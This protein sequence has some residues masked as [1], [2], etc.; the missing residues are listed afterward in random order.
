[1]FK[2]ALRI[3]LAGMALMFLM[4]CQGKKE[5]APGE[6][7][8]KYPTHQVGA[9]SSAAANAEMV[10]T[11]NEK[12]KGKYRIEVEEIPGDQ[13]YADK[14]KV[15][16][17]SGQLPDLVY[18]PDILLDV[19]YAQGVCMD[20]TP[21][22]NADPQWKA[23]FPE[24]VL[25][26]N[27]RDGKVIAL[28]NEG[29]LIGY[30]YN[31]ELFEKAG[32]AGP[33][34]TWDEFFQICAKLKAAG[35][36]PISM[37]TGDNA[38]CS[39]LVLTEMIAATGSEGYAFTTSSSFHENYSIPS[40]INGL[41]QLQRIWTEGYTTRDSIGGMYEHAA[42]NFISGRTAMIANGTWMIGS[43]SDPDM[44]GSQE[45]ADNV[46]IALFPGD[47]YISNP[48]EGFAICAKTPEGQEAALAML[49]HWTSAETQLSNLRSASGLLPSGTIEIPQDVIEKNR[50]LGQILVLSRNGK[51]TRSL[52][53]LWYPGVSDV[54][55]QQLALFA[56]G[57][58]SA[59]ALAGEITRIAQQNKP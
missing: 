46:E 44:G 5:A 10:R 26:H 27:T 15:L 33:A 30:Y 48:F 9:N 22:L 6:Y 13:N 49:K 8:I 40:F 32:V 59:E 53:N 34:K 57:Q 50:L 3:C 12:Y 43:F 16:A 35:I 41:K 42:N 52:S 45:F 31:R 51:A 56:A 36:T 47:F 11:F 1:M 7:V 37:Q 23:L 24:M 4:A 20:L 28:P 18:T 58:T 2:H 54:F 55:S 29:Q 14:M 17:V 39:Q 25:N 21:A 19:L 38:W